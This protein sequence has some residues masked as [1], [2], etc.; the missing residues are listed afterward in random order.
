MNNSI[1]LHADTILDENGY[2]KSKDAFRGYSQ[3]QMKQML[4]ENEDLIRRKRY[5]FDFFLISL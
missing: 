1:I 4:L 5:S 3:G 2:C